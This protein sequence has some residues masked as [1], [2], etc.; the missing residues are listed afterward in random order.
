[1]LKKIVIVG[2]GAAGLPLSTMLGNKLGKQGTAEITLVDPQDSHIWKPRFHEL[3]TGA[4][5]SDLDALNYRLHGVRKHFFFEQGELSGLDR[6]NKKI[7]LNPTFDENGEEV[8]PARQLAYDY[9]V[10]ALGSHTNDFGVPSVREHCYCIDSRAQA[11]HFR[12]EFISKCLRADYNNGSLNIAIIGGGPTG[13]ELSAELLNSVEQ[14]KYYGLRKLTRDRLQVHI[15]EA[16]P[17]ILNGLHPRVAAATLEQLQ[18]LGITVSTST[19][20]IRIEAGHIETADGK[21][22]ESDMQIWAAGVLAPPMLD[23][24][25]G[26]ETNPIH[27]L[28]VEPTL[29]TTQD[30]TIFALGDCSA[31]ANGEHLPPTAQAAQ[32]MADHSYMAIQCL[33]RGQAIPPFEYNN[34][35]ALVSLASYDSVGNLSNIL[36]RNVFIEGWLARR[37]YISMYRIHQAKLF[38]W[39]RTLAL[40]LAG[41][42][43]RLIRPGL[44]LH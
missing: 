20:V 6:A 18:K 27:Q 23:T 36:G 39:P 30:P 14:L 40:L 26:L 25:D 41:R 16:A 22:I 31:Q 4:L 11:E 34:R 7:S 9:L 13:V 24:L 5:D 28:L 33:L 43:S 10:I 15:F 29:Q 8:L 42:F 3:A 38:G 32:Q 44:K 21:K 2:G 1:M 17:Q 37:M 12:N 35:G 19:H